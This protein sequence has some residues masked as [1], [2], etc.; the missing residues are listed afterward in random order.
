MKHRFPIQRWMADC[1]RVAAVVLAVI[2]GVADAEEARD[3]QVIERP[4]LPSDVHRIRVPTQA[5][6]L[7]RI[8]VWDFID[9]QPSFDVAYHRRVKLRLFVSGLRPTHYRIA[10]SRN[11]TG[12]DWQP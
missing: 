2:G 8:K 12:A 9:G 11:F 6:V 5:P 7:G 4:R 10:E 1:V 3:S